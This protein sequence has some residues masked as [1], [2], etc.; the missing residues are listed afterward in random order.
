VGD[1]AVIGDVKNSHRDV[2]RGGIPRGFHVQLASRMEIDG[3]G[4]A[5][6]TPRNDVSG[7]CQG[8]AV[9]NEDV[10][11]AARSVGDAGGGRKDLLHRHYDVAVHGEHRRTDTGVVVHIQCAA[12]H[13][14]ADIWARYLDTHLDRVRI[15]GAATEG[16]SAVSVS[17]SIISC[18]LDLAASEYDFV[19]K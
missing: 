12:T 9:V 14:A 10:R 6:G 17:G 7:D 3:G 5:T 4:P 2:A 15:N 16:K 13:A 18:I 19:H 11:L 1:N 8:T